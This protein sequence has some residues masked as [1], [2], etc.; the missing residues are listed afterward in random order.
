MN[1]TSSLVSVNPCF[2]PIAIDFI[3]HMKQTH[4]DMS[5]EIEML[6]HEVESFRQ[7]MSFHPGGPH[8]VLYSQH[9]VPPFPGMHQGPPPPHPGA[10]QASG[11]P[12]APEGESS[13]PSFPPGEG[14]STNGVVTSRTG[15][16]SA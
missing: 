3:A 4:T 7:G 14:P 15:T 10:P 16:P 11:H 13:Q 1:R 8:P 12:P 5:R 6:R 9:V 2:L